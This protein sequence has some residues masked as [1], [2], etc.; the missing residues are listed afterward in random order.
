MPESGLPKSVLR[1]S[2]LRLCR[3]LLPAVLIAC[4]WNATACVAQ[5][6]PGAQP[7]VP[8][9]PGLQGY[10][11]EV[12]DQWPPGTGGYRFARVRITD[13]QTTAPQ[14]ERRFQV[15]INVKPSYYSSNT[16]STT[17]V[18]LTIEGGK[19]TA[20][21]DIYFPNYDFGST[22]T[23]LI[24]EKEGGS[25]RYEN[26]DL[27]QGF[28][29]GTSD[30]GYE[31]L[32]LLF[33]NSDITS[34]ETSASVWAR[35]SIAST[36][37]FGAGYD[38]DTLPGFGPLRT[39]YSGGSTNQ[40][41]VGG[42]WGGVTT[43][44][45][46]SVQE[47]EPSGSDRGRDIA[48]VLA[49]P[50]VHSIPLNDLPEKWTGLTGINLIF[51]PFSDLQTLSSSSSPQLDLLRTWV[52]AGG[53]IVIYDDQSENTGD[54]SDQV[55]GTL[56]VLDRAN[57]A[58]KLFAGLN[59]F[60]GDRKWKIPG[61]KIE[62]MARVYLGVDQTEWYYYDESNQ[63]DL[64]TTDRPVVVD[65]DWVA[66]DTDPAGLSAARHFMLCEYVNGTICFVGDNMTAWNTNRWIPLL[67]T[68]SLRHGTVPQKIGLATSRGEPAAGMMIEGVGRPPIRIFQFLICVFLFAIGPF[69]YT[70][71]RKQNRMQLLFVIVPSASLLVCVGLLVFAALSDGF[72]TRG[73]MRS[74]T[75]IDHRTDAAV[76]WS[77]HSYY[78]GIQ[79]GRYEFGEDS[80]A[81]LTKAWGS[82]RVL[83]DYEN[84]NLRLSGGDARPRM[85]HQVFSVHPFS[86][87]EQLEI[88]RDG[89][90]LQIT[91]GYQ[92]KL[93]VAWLRT[94]DGLFRIEELEAG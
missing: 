21:A 64:I 94:P 26:Y 63:G 84:G 62:G 65:T 76:T 19:L 67:N 7:V 54:I 13:T 74:F 86:T 88:F 43:I 34:S 83:Y 24:V 27:H 47:S 79:P 61:P 70:I 51:L 12:N 81:F 25:R 3:L 6:N 20:T 48:E 52:S 80:A 57:Q 82:R 11:T 72:Q 46:P 93:L 53:F 41:V 38:I 60:P 35:N 55:P 42:P 29:A 89:S 45:T 75:T 15:V 1:V 17:V 40:M 39:I 31:R 68:A 18:P 71:L 85:P 2:G 73:R 91:N 4:I 32:N 59:D 66:P 23:E 28:L 92:S 44:A 58:G 78:R 30:D 5:T 90:S 77:Q 10:V 87:G 8:V 49:H 9:P 14:L 37:S 50:Q 33:V 36:H 69:C 56:E 22:Y 16:H